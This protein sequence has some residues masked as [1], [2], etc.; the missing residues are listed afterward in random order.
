MLETWAIV[1]VVFV[2]VSA[3]ALIAWRPVHRALREARFAQERRDFHRQR[4]R[5]EARYLHLAANSGRAPHLRWSECEF[6]NDVTYARDK[7][8]GRLCAFVAV[9]IAC[10]QPAFG[11]VLESSLGEEF[12][13]VANVKAATAVFHYEKKRWH[14]LGRTV[15]HLSPDEAL[16]R[17]KDVFVPLGQELARQQ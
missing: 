6:S 5:L 14:T 13:A 1:V 9:T 10:D 7:R 16:A 11:G 4:E 17:Y 8:T 12:G 3:I 15:F 2:A